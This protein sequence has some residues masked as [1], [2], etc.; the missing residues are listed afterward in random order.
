MY[1]THRFTYCKAQGNGIT[2]AKTFEKIPHCM[3]YLEG[4]CDPTTH[5][6]QV[7]T[8]IASYNPNLPLMQCSSL[9]PEPKITNYP[10]L[11]SS[12]KVIPFSNKP[13]FIESLI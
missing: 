2:I 1:L 3:Y 7:Q 12:S 13:Q 11:T 5:W 6:F 8:K 10:T 4:T 9:W